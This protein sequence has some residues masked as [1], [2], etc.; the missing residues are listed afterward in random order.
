LLDWWFNEEENR[1]SDSECLEKMLDLPIDSEVRIGAAI[2]VGNNETHVTTPSWSCRFSETPENKSHAQL[3]A[4]PDDRW[5]QNEVS[6]RA[7]V[8][9]DKMTALRDLLI[10]TYRE[11][12]DTPSTINWVDDSLIQLHR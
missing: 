1:A 11:S 2:A 5:E 4:K 10:K 12:N 8:M 3:F 9:V 6:Q 7:T